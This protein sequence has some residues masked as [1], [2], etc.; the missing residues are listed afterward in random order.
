M[1]EQRDDIWAVRNPGD[2]VV[3]T[4]NGTLRGDGGLVMGRGIAKEACSKY[5]SLQK[6]LGHAVKQN[7]LRLEVL[8]TMR[9]VAFPVKVEFYQKADLDLILRSTI[10]LVEAL[11]K[12]FG[13]RILMPRPGCGNGKLDWLQVEPIVKHYLTDDRI[14]VFTK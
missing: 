4:T 9:L 1:N 14:T 12:L 5:P 3:V 11:P 2:W 10:Q 13:G 6:V 7:G 8:E